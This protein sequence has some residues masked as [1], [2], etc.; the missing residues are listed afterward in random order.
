MVPKN[1]A[2]LSKITMRS[3]ND[4]AEKGEIGDLEDVGGS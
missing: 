4:L 2:R 3:G 1:V